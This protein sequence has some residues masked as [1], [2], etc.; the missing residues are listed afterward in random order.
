MTNA[1]DQIANSANSTID[2][3]EQ[4]VKSTSV[5]PAVGVVGIGTI[6]AVLGI[7]A[8]GAFGAIVGATLGATLATNE[9]VKLGKSSPSYKPSRTLIDVGGTSK[10][11]ISDDIT[12]L[13]TISESAPPVSTNTQTIQ[14]V[15]LDVDGTLVLSN[16]A[17]T[18]G[19]IEGYAEHGYDISFDQ[20]RP[21]IGMG[22]DQLIPKVTP[23]LSGEEGV[24]KEIA[25]RRKQLIMEKFGA[26]LQP[27][28]G[29]RELVQR[30]KQDGFQLVV[31]S[32]A[33]SEEL[34]I[35]LKAAQVNDLLETEP[36]TTSSDADVS[37]PAPDLVQVALGKAHLQPEQSIMLGDTPYDIESA[38]KA[39][40]KVI[41]FRCGGFDDSQL[42]GAIAIYND[43]ADLLAHYDQSPLGQ[44]ATVQI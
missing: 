37:K 44:R 17:H 15:L 27:A 39:G 13:E 42:Q 3:A 4:E 11:A 7:I 9:N 36:T 30:L 32:S 21:L 2:Q 5:H 25:D 31:A 16:D 24:G 19:F 33:T 8:G 10:K 23:E 28:P 20:V 41:A 14:G 12:G 18:Q 29:A 6:G 40:V 35:L 38:G 43:P 22:S 34:S 26:E 1:I